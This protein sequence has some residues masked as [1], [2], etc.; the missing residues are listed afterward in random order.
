MY[1]VLKLG[2]ESVISYIIASLIVPVIAGIGYLAG[3]Y[4]FELSIYMKKFKKAPPV[5]IQNKNKA[6]QNKATQNKYGKTS[7]NSVKGTSV[8]GKYKK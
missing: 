7:Q 1:S 6:T 8:Q 2:H 3:F 5:V 4:G